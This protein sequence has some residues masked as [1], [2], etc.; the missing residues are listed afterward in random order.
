VGNQIKDW[1]EIN[2]GEVEMMEK[3]TLVP[4]ARIPELLEAAA[5]LLWRSSLSSGLED[6]I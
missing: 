2:E 3:P 5:D 4:F 6:I 1:R